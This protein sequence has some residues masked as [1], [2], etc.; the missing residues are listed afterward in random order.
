M[1]R[2]NLLRG[3]V[4]EIAEGI[5]LRILASKVTTT[6]YVRPDGGVLTERTNDSRRTQ[7]LP[8][9]WLVGVYTRSTKCDELEDD[10]VVRLAELTG[11][12][13]AA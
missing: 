7:D 10:L 8:D 13:V 3:D 6:V 4:E 5:K 9:S 2:Y 11:R 1:T 12:K